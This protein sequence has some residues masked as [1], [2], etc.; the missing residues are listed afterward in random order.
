[1][2][3]RLL[4]I[5]VTFILSTVSLVCLAEEMVSDSTAVNTVKIDGTSNTLHKTP[6]QSFDK[7]RSLHV[8]GSNHRCRNRRIVTVCI[9]SD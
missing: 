6:F 4:F 5:V 8:I 2:K 3:K 7:R 1:M 9:H